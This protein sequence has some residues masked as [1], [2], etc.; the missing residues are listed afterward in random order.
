MISYKFRLYPSKTTEA[1]LLKQLE[2][3]RWLYNCLLFELNKAKEEGRKLRQADTQS[4]IVKFKEENPNLNKV[5]SKVLQMVN[6]QLWANIKALAKLKQN[7]KRVGKLRYKG[8]WFKTL[9]FN[10]SGFKIEGNR[11]IL[12]KIGSVPIKLHRQ[13]DG[14]TKGVIVKRE[15]SGRWYAIAQVE[16]EPKP[17][18]STGKC[19]GIDVG[20]KHFLTDS[21]GRQIENPRFYEKALKRVKLLQRNLSRKQKDSKNREKA[22]IKLAKAYEKLVNQRNDFLHKLSCFYINNYDVIVVEDLRIKNIVCSNLA[23]KILDAS[24]GKFI[25]LL[26]YK[27]ERA[28]RKVVRV[29]PRGASK[30]LSFDDSYRDYISACRIKN[31]GLG[32]GQPLAP[33]ERRPLLLVTSSAGN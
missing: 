33:V 19:I 12:S 11:L 2:L 23:Q 3:C 14:K 29:N 8:K 20:I 27:A 18:S 24:W 17:L 4:L 22:R 1:K 26:S 6:Y 25:Q 15:K 7:G 16:D 10:Q 31:R 5:Y 21:D 13:I 32:L 28:G 30:C 9:N